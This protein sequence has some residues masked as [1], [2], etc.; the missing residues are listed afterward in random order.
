MN[1]FEDKNK[2]KWDRIIDPKSENSLTS[3]REILSYKELYYR[4]VKRDFTIFYKQTILGP[5]WYII[6]PLVY[7]V[8]FTIIFGNFAKIPTDGIPPFLFYLTGNLIWSYYSYCLIQNSNIFNSNSGL[9]SK[10]YFPRL[11]IPITNL[12]NGI[13]QFT[14][15]FIIYLGFYS[16]FYF[17][18]SEISINY[19]ILLLPLVLLHAGILGLG[20]GLIISSIVTKYRDL[21]LA[22]NLITQAWLY[23]SPIIYPL[24]QVP[25]NLRAIYVLNP[26]VAIIELFKKIFLN[27]SSI[28]LNE[29]LLSAFI[30]LVLLFI[31]LRVFIKTEKNFI[32]TV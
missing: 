10:V 20:V 23:A 24:S 12:T 18:G 21:T 13:V 26:T 9:F 27:V 2:E 1:N 19:F 31:G 14:V 7:T 30:T 11:I 29:Y 17:S 5:L 8:I 25:E 15:Q 4:L 3:F 28:T 32:D 22:L 16:Y 6:Q